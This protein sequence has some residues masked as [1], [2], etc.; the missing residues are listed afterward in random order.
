ML[1]K[2]SGSAKIPIPMRDVACQD[3]ITDRHVIH[4]GNLR[5]RTMLNNLAEKVKVKQLKKLTTVI[6]W[7]QS[8]IVLHGGCLYIYD[9][10]TSMKPTRATS[11]YGFT[12]IEPCGQEVGAGVSWPFKLICALQ[13]RD[14]TYYF[15]APSEKDLKVWIKCIE[16]QMQ[17]IFKA[18]ERSV[19]TAF[20]SPQ[21]QT[22]GRAGNMSRLPLPPLPGMPEAEYVLKED[23]EDDESPDDYTEI[24]EVDMDL[25]QEKAQ[26]PNVR[27]VS[28]SSG[29]SP[30]VP[31]TNTPPRTAPRPFQP[32]TTT[33]S[34]SPAPA[35]KVAPKPKATSAATMFKSESID[36]GHKRDSSGSAR[37]EDNVEYVGASQQYLDMSDDANALRNTGIPPEAYWNGKPD[38]ADDLMKT[39]SYNGTYMLRDS[40]EKGAQTLIVRVDSNVVKYKIQVNEKGHIALM[41]NGPYFESMGS[42]INFYKSNNIPKHNSP[43]TK[44]YSLVRKA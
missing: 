8:Y 27:N 44:A 23:D 6:R 7:R 29:R 2:M 28:A 33:G 43:L 17:S 30:V 41:A 26:L 3:L 38:E 12:G 32:P 13:D 9:N 24:D 39:L 21:S 19:P 22:T 18:N 36:T 37:L 31:P 34:R 14:R 4:H 15:S 5:R 10:E 11:L 42:L 25:P 20:V 1:H 16:D 35:P 40:S